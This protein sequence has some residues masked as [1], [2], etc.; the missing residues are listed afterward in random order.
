[1]SKASRAFCRHVLAKY[2]LDQHHVKL[3]TLLCEALDRGEQARQAIARDGAYLHDRFGQLKA[4]PVV[5]VERD[6]RI[7]A[8][9]LTREL[10]LDGTPEPDPRQPRPASVR[11]S[12]NGSG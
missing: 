6:A 7:A 11:M 3:L 8:A 10:D 1:L 9:R 4:H 12:A 2:E 5:A